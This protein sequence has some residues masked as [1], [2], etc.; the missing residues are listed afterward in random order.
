[1][2]VFYLQASARLACSGQGVC[3]SVTVRGRSRVMGPRATVEEAAVLTSG[4]GPPVNTVRTPTGL[5]SLLLLVY[6]SVIQII[7]PNFVF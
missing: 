4:W 3:T 5:T 2:C 6:S 1:M 7:K